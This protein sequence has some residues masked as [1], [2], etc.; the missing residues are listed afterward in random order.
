MAPPEG[1]REGGED[2]GPRPAD[3]PGQ[4][5]VL[6]FGRMLKLL[7]VRA[8]V[9]RDEFGAQLGYSASS[10]ASFEQGRRIP[11]PRVIERADRLLDAGGVLEALKE[12]VGR[13]QYPAF[14]RDAARLEAEAVELLSY[15]S[16][17]VKGLLQTEDYMRAILR[18]RRPLL[19]DETIEQRVTARLARQ[20]IFNRRPA[21]LLS[22][23]L[24]E[25][26]LR[27]GWG[28]T[29]VRRGQLEHLL[30]IDEKRNVEIQVMPMDREDNAGV[31]GPFTVITKKDGS[32][33][34]YMEVQGR[35]SLLTAPEDT[36]PAA[37]R[38]G[39][40]RSQALSPRESMR[41]I[42]KLLGDL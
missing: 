41:F 40:I 29:E 32:R 26:V 6:A 37:S 42:E 31:D 7:R 14:F 30:L 33:F 13:A 11:P 24:E 23:V 36:V 2:D 5:V 16:H 27:Q 20:E 39:I 1:L 3:D 22:F 12:D 10:I 21:P 38:Y 25:S 15:D 4:G 17:A 34:V 28:G 35:S 8:G 9:P 19:D 18:M